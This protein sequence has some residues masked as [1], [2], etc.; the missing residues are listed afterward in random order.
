M[1]KAKIIES[2]GAG[3]YTVQ[4]DYGAEK[5]AALIAV[6]DQRIADQV[7]ALAALD[8]AIAG[9]EA[10]SEEVRETFEVA[11]FEL[12][13]AATPTDPAPEEQ[14]KAFEAAVNGLNK[15]TGELQGIRT[16]R[17]QASLL[18]LELE[19]RKAAI[20][21]A[22]PAESELAWCADFTEGATG[23]V[24]TIEIPGEAQT[25]FVPKEVESDPASVALLVRPQGTAPGYD[26][27]RDG[28]L[29][30]REW[31]S[32]E[33]AFFNA[34]ILP[35][36]QRWEPTY[37]SGRIVAISADSQTCSVELN[38]AISSASELPVNP[39]ATTLHAVPVDYMS[40]GIDAFEEG[41]EVVI[42]LQARDWLQPKVI[43]FLHH[44]KPCIAGRLVWMPEGFS[45][46]PRSDDAPMGWGLPVVDGA[47]TLG[48]PLPFALVNRKQHNNYPDAVAGKT[49]RTAGLCYMPDD[50]ID[51]PPLTRLG[52]KKGGEIDPQFGL[53][54][55]QE[56]AEIDA[57]RWYAHWPEFMKM[58]PIQQAILDRTNEY[59]AEVGLPPMY[60]ALRGYYAGAADDALAEIQKSGIQAHN[61][62]AFRVGYRTFFDRAINRSAIPATTSITENLATARSVAGRTAEQTG[63]RLAEVWRDSPP[64]YA[65]MIGTYHGTH[66]GFQTV[67]FLH[68]STGFGVV[69]QYEDTSD[70]SIIKTLDPPASGTIGVQVYSGT[71]KQINVGIAY[72]SGSAGA[73]SWFAATSLKYATVQVSGDISGAWDEWAL[74]RSFV[75]IRGR[76]RPVYRVGVELASVRAVMGAALCFVGD[77]LRLRVC[78]LNESKMLELWDGPSWGAWSEFT[79]LTSFDLTAG[80]DGADYPTLVGRPIF[81]QSGEKCIIRLIRRIYHTGPKLG[82]FQVNLNAA[83]D[84]TAM[85]VGSAIDFIEFSSGSFSHVHRSRLDV[86]PVTR[87]TTGDPSTGARNEHVLQCQGSYKWLA[88]YDGET[89]VYATVHVDNLASQWAEYTFS[90]GDYAT[91]G[92]ALPTVS[93]QETHLVAETRIEFPSGPDM[94]TLECEITDWVATGFELVLHTIDI[95]HPERTAF[96]RLT[97]GNRTESAPPRPLIPAALEWSGET[98]RSIDDVTPGSAGRI[99]P[100]AWLR[101]CA[102]GSG[103]VNT[104]AR[105]EYTNGTTGEFFM[106]Y[107][108]P[109]GVL[110]D[111]ATSALYLAQGA[112]PEQRGGD[113]PRDAYPA[114][115][116]A[117]GGLY[118]GEYSA[119]GA[120]TLSEAISPRLIY[121]VGANAQLDMW[122]YGGEW[123]M[124]GR[125]IT[126]LRGYASE[127]LA[128]PD[129]LFWRATFDLQ[130]AVGK[131]LGNSIDPVGVV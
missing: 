81:S 87:E 68:I 43:G 30:P 36:W 100:T 49:L 27:F 45:L 15:I 6:L 24:G 89:L 58:T 25:Y 109:R 103:I 11:E 102:W 2:L 67:G 28:V 16:Q 9:L 101:G 29:L 93:A 7:I 19:K 113:C 47:P 39:S 112:L 60:P 13:E 83:A 116:G 26:A 69:S 63:V 1:G 41:D 129:R 117:D 46:W 44:P 90:G 128:E 33:Q 64:H 74:Q 78:T 98:I 65:N 57:G 5:L 23:D 120:L 107:T 96:S 121:G 84:G 130:A 106:A 94:V 3:L 115:I 122:S 75:A 35:G 124:R 123:I 62:E 51:A 55:Q 110:Y 125:Y 18:K 80:Y 56:S 34:A 85:A 119:H 118:G 91:P 86:T 22:E 20:L 77:V 71:N 126:P 97:Y 131:P 40:C 105:L 31:M 48:G 61:S 14:M 8:E 53:R 50:D 54:W 10:K 42:E 108:H 79:V 72:W 59:R 38:P 95:L 37:R 52:V 92:G 73:V 21:S 76:V 66:D 4:R 12:A 111:E 82:A 99:V 70:G 127:G 17:S 88:D 114:N 104:K 32:P